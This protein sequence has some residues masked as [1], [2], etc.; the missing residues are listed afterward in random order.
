MGAAHLCSSDIPAPQAESLAIASLL[1]HSLM[2]SRQARCRPGQ[3]QSV[4]DRHA[5]PERV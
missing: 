3:A 2:P 5:T 4:R 1:V